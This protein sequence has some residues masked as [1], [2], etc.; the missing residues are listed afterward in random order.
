MKKSVKSEKVV[1]KWLG[2][3]QGCPREVVPCRQ[4][5]LCLFLSRQAL[6]FPI[7]HSDMTPLTRSLLKISRPVTT[8]LP[9]S[10]FTRAVFLKWLSSGD[11]LVE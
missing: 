2:K 6:G 9:H 1:K 3:E 11:A 8:P 4:P 7:R 10:R 5:P